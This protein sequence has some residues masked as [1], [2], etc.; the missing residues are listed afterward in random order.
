VQVNGDGTITV[1]GKSVSKLLIDGKQFFGSDLKIATKN[2]DA[3]IVNSI[4]VYDDRENDPDH[5]ISD[6][7]V[8][9]IINLKLKKAIKR[10]IFGKVFAGGGTRNRYE[11][12]GLFNLFR[13]TLQVSIIG[14]S[15]NLNQTAFSNDELYSQ[16]GF[17]RSGGNNLYNG[18]VNTGGQSWGGIEKITSGGF[19]INTD[20]G[21]KLKL[22]LL[23]FYSQRNNAGQ[24]LNKVQRTLGDT[25]INTSSNS[26]NHSNNYAHN[27]TG[28]IDWEP[29]TLNTI[30]YAPKLSFKRDESGNSSYSDSYN[31]LSGHLSEVSGSSN[32]KG[33][34]TDFSQDFYYNKRFKGKK[35]AS[36]NIAHSLQYNPSSSQ[37]VSINNLHSFVSTLK[38]DTL[39]RQGNGA[40]K[41][42]SA[43][44]NLSVRYPFTKKLTVDVVTSG[45][46]SQSVER[47]Q[48]YDFNKSTG[49][50]DVYL[51]SQ[52]TNFKRNLFTQD[53]KPGIT[54]RFT[55]GISVIAG[56]SFNWQQAENIFVSET[57]Y[58]N[59]LF[60]LPTVR[61]ELGPVSV[62]YNRSASLP[63]L[64]ALQP[65]TIVYN[66][67]YTFTGNPFL[68]PT[69]SNNFNAN[70]N[71]YFQKQELNLYFYGSVNT[72]EDAVIQTQL[73]QASGAQATNFVNRD[74]QTNANLS[75][76]IY[77][78]FKKM[79]KWTV[80]T[81]TSMYMYY[82][83]TLNI[84]NSVEG[85]QKSM[86]P[87]ANQ[88]FNINWNDKVEL[89]A[90]AGYRIGRT[91]YDYGDHKTVNTNNFNMNNNLVVRW[92]A[93][94]V[95][96]TKQDFNY[97][98][99]VANGLQK[100]INVVSSSIALQMLKKDRGEIKI[101]GYDL[102]NQNTSVYRYASDNIIYDVQN[103]TLKRYF[104]L[105]LTYK[106]NSLST[107]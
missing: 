28:L 29:D 94:I 85:W 41:S 16:G 5:L 19:N 42:F 92:P 53:V 95:W 12:G 43:Q 3:A 64:S 72:E 86:S 47:N 2:L 106:F 97:N 87:G 23:Y 36:I 91:K 59:Y 17:N 50:Y 73:S 4:Q 33:H 58:H 10:S 78:R 56:V 8:Q 105:T 57:N 90:G 88:S 62:G 30:H 34:G 71:K 67:L 44:L 26:E 75:M 48:V 98:S 84:I 83:R 35:D 76:G 31:N 96:E 68:K 46:Y 63:W 103:N 61:L 79:G 93:H 49:L 107:K 7:K 55:P 100:S 21:K 51:L 89:N 14:L 81:N 37:G 24:S 45:S 38:S 27:I 20:Y 74:G 60:V 15:N 40:N 104:L 9:K 80:N 54:Y 25:V 13:D 66:P 70:F 18:T 1:N 6:T 65:Q 99:Q 22:N 101:T 52:S 102:F 82:R 69:I 32:N 39:N 77:K 11:S